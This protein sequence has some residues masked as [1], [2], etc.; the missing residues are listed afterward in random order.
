[1][2]NMPFAPFL[3]TVPALA[4]MSV[5]ALS[6]CSRTE[7]PQEPIRAV[8]VLTVGVDKFQSEHEFAGDVRARVE[9]RL[10]FRVGGKIVRRQAELGQRVKA[11][12]VLA[13]LDPQDYRLAA[14]SARAQ[15]AAA[16]TNR[17]LAA[18]DF[19][20]YAALKD[21]NFIS[22][23]ELERR[24]TTLKAAQAQLEQANAQLASQGHQ[25]EYTSLV[26]DVSGVVTAIEAEPGQVVSAGTPVVRIAQDGP[27]DVVFAVPEDKVVAIKPGSDV[28]VRVWAENVSL[29]GNVR[30]VAASADP[31]TRTYAVKVSLDASASPP[32]GATAYVSPKAL[33]LA[34]APVIKLPTSALRK[35]GQGTAVWV[36]DKATMTVKSQPVQIATAD[37]NDAV[38]SSGLK[39][40]M[41]V[42]SAG[43]HVLSPG[44]KVT[45]YQE[46]TSQ[47]NAVAVQEA[48]RNVASSMG[49]AQAATLPATK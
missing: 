14:D 28:A 41:M 20:R 21:Q 25:A 16:Q 44:Q 43:V 12:Q 18:A 26:A 2:P 46:K 39:P 45:I 19:K 31:A 37:G 15:V 36:V 24:E 1:M 10:G 27:R 30:E 32:L 42:V 48:T 23:A 3:P 49:A 8:K 47:S 34:G 5:L 22:G 29:E 17:D 7:A 40:G 11:G 35:E 38:I 4:L 13:Q 6:A 33:S 9:S